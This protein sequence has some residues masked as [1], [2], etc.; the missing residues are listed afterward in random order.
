MTLLRRS[1][2]GPSATRSADTGRAWSRRQFLARTG[3]GLALVVGGGFLLGGSAADPVDAVE[4]YA[5]RPDLSPP[6]VDVIRR[7]EKTA[8]GYVFVATMHG[9][10]QRGPMIVDNAGQLVWFRPLQNA[11]A[12]N[13][14][15]QRYRGNPVLVWWEGMVTN[16][17]GLGEYV[18]TDT[19]YTEVGRVRAGNGLKGD[20]HEFVITPQDTAFLTAYQTV[21]ADLSSVGGAAQGTLLDSVVQEV[22]IASGRVLFEWRPSDH[23]ALSESYC[24]LS[25]EPFDFF[26]ANSIDVG[27]DGNLLVSARHTWAVYKID[28]ISGEIIWRLGG[29]R[30]DFTMGPGTTFYWQH[31][32]RWG[33]DRSLTI[34]DDGDGFKAEETESRGIRLDIDETARSVTLGEQYVHKGYLAHAL[35]SMQNLSDG[36][37][38][39]GWGTVP[40]FSEFS[41]D[42]RLRFDAVVAGGESYRAFRQTWTGHPID[43][44]AV[45]LVQVGG[46][47]Y[48]FA[49][50][51][52]STSLRAWR[53]NAGATPDALTPRLSVP[54]TGFETKIPL[55]KGHGYI[56]VD[57]LNANGRVLGSVGPIKTRR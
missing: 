4:H 21:P 26:H 44:P 55:K 28:R 18:L 3:S 27:D 41:P 7:A 37:A 12:T 6:Q 40:G 1:V 22:D 35:G 29:K 5:S 16:G 51:N 19:T 52:G 54:S 13:F 38:F 47:H 24:S 33:R 10:G 15:V 42:G 17:Y 48:A 34:F 46:S 56:A 36:G 2:V 20:L 39:V 45:A 50:W 14:G 30:S 32:A 57:A 43:R 53:L 49:S 25:D 9:P 11:M 31:D 23:V 8:A